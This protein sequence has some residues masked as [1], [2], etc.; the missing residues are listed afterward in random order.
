MRL[1]PRSL[2]RLFPERPDTQPSTPPWGPSSTLPSPHLDSWE[3][4]LLGAR[5]RRARRR[6]TPPA[7]RPAAPPR[8][9]TW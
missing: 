4:L 6:Q 8:R 2:E 7:A 5:L 3:A 1:V 9:Q